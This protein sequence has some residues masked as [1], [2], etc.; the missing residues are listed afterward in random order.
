MEPET[1][2]KSAR[3]LETNV[4]A[5]LGSPIASTQ[6]KEVIG[7]DEKQKRSPLG[8]YILANRLSEAASPT[9]RLDPI[10][11]LPPEISTFI[12]REALPPDSDY[13]PQL[14]DLT[15]VSHIWQRF[16]LS[17]PSLWSEIY[18]DDRNP[19]FLATVATSAHLSGKVALKITTYNRPIN[20]WSSISTILAPICQRITSLNVLNMR[21]GPTY[22]PGGNHITSEISNIF[23]HLGHLPRLRELAYAGYPAI[24]ISDFVDLPPTTCLTGMIT[25][26]IPSSAQ[27]SVTPGRFFDI[28]KYLSFSPV[29]PVVPL[30]SHFSLSLRR[31]VCHTSD[32]PSNIIGRISS[33]MLPLTTL[34]AFHRL[35]RLP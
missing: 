1:I 23:D 22:V 11:S 15:N 19:D 4:S 6:P 18:L 9:R 29:V 7:F 10:T 3:Y 13:C 16:I 25:V 30:F 21:F 35:S 34:R 5:G 32:T 31:R 2:R 24:S 20:C 17:T 12:I 26:T 14:L 8:G 33:L 27:L 28:G